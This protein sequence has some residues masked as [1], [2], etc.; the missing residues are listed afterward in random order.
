[1]KF[2]E[3]IKRLDFFGKEPEFYMNGRPKQVTIIGRIFTYIYLIIY[4][5]IFSY[6]LYRMTQ[7]IDITFYDSYSNTDEIPTI[8]LTP[9]N[10]TLIFTLLDEFGEPFIDDTIY[11]PEAYFFLDGNYEPIDLEICNPKKLSP[12]FVEYFKALGI[13]NYFCLSN[14]NFEFRPFL[15]LIRIE[16]YPCI[17]SDEDDDYCETKE[18][19][20]E[21]LQN[22]LFMVYFEDIMLTP[23]N[24]SSP[25]KRRINHLNTELFHNLGQY[26]SS[27]MQLVKVETSTNIIGFDFLTESKVDDFIKFDKEVVL[28]YPGY[29]LYDGIYT[30]P[31]SIFELQLNDKILLETRKYVNLIDVLGEIGGFLEIIQSLFTLICSIFTEII[32]EKRITNN[33]FSF[34]ISKNVI[35]LKNAKKPI[36]KINEDKNLEEIK[37]INIYDLDRFKLNN[38]NNRN[39][40]RKIMIQSINKNINDNNNENKSNLEMNP[41]K[42]EIKIENIDDQSIKHSFENIN[43]NSVEYLFHT[44][45]KSVKDNENNLIIE[46]INLIDVL[47]SKCC[48]SRCFRKRRKV[49]DI[50]LEESMNIIIEKLDIFNIFR[51]IYSIDYTN[52]YLNKNF[53]IIKISEESTKKLSEIIK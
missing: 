41:L 36:I 10:F 29:D 21:Y 1:M 35:L 50:I 18:F 2:C 27:Q 16:I 52:T 13:T 39:K 8:K 12:E 53:D 43:K 24:F 45:K 51:T 49:Y 22:R 6:K 23:L 40:E 47:I 7:R 20:Q 37:E 46:K 17:N 19:V 48:C 34:N 9:D 26:L 14:I 33:L 42:K 38:I 5:L 25:V 44:T 30:Y 28:P 4:I 31:L 3:C 32:Y 15:N 11:Y